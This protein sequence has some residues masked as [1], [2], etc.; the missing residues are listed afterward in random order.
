MKK[1]VLLLSVVVLIAVSSANVF[2]GGGKV[3]GGEGKGFVNQCQEMDP[4]PFKD[5]D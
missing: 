5:L 4:P 3:R 2:A 1:L